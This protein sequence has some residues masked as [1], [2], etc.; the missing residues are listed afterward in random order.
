MLVQ[1]NQVSKNYSQVPLFEKIS[2][3]VNQGEKIGVIGHNGAG[4]TTLFELISGRESADTGS[5]SRKKGLKIAYMKQQNESSDECVIDYLLSCFGEL[6]QIKQQMNH[7]ESEMS[8]GVSDIESN[9]QAYGKLQEAFE[10]MNGYT[11]E[12]QVV[13]VLKGLGLG[14]KINEKMNSLSGGQRMQVDLARMLVSDAD[15]LLLDEPTNH[16]D[17]EAMKWLTDYLR[18]TKK[19]YLLISHDRYFLDQTVQKIIE[20]EDGQLC[21]YRGNYSRYKELRKEKDLKWQHD[22]DQQQKEIAKVRKQIKQFRQW[23]YE[24]DND[25]F[26][27]KAKELERRLQKIDYITKPPSEKNKIPDQLSMNGKLGKEIIRVENLGCMMGEKFLFSDSSFLI[28]RGEHVAVIGKNGSGKS[29]LFRLILGE[30]EADE[31]EIR[32]NER[33]RIGYLPQNI[34]FEEGTQRVVAYVKKIVGNEQRARNEL[35][36]FGFFA[37]DV[38]KR[39]KDLSGGEKVRLKLL[40]LFQQPIDLLMLDEP[41]NHLDIQSREEVEGILSNYKGT[42]LAI[43]H[44]Q[45]FLMNHFTKKLAI[46]DGE[47]RLY[48][49]EPNK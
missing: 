25:A 48:D 28:R 7:L 5:I 24:G 40:E 39:L 14:E 32:V 13:S 41:T 17:S 18:G 38:S 20:L 36:H 33:V 19:A 44:D 37:E 3:T 12:D 4:K 16:L 31:G 47:I 1:L 27:K 45:Y 10:E 42:V 11:M 8:I 26:F 35:A 30:I 46:E 29:T 21:E 22:Y 34:H 6:M 49:E 9:L 15:L 23:G 43:S 2:F